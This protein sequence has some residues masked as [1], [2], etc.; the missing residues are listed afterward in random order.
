M[1]KQQP[2]SD[3]VKQIHF[4]AA[5]LKAPRIVDAMPLTDAHMPH[6]STTSECYYKPWTWC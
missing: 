5:A 4:L 6:P 1:A 2:V 3:A